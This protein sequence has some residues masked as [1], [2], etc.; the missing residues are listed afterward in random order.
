[1]ILSL[2]QII[3]KCV[4]RIKCYL[5]QHSDCH[6]LNRS[7]LIFTAAPE[8]ARTDADPDAKRLATGNPVRHQSAP[9]GEVRTIVELR[10]D[11]R[12][13]RE[14][15]GDDRVEGS[16]ERGHWQI[17]D[18]R[19]QVLVGVPLRGRGPRGQSRSLPVRR[20][21]PQPRP[22]GE[23]SPRPSSLSLDYGVDSKEWFVGLGGRRGRGVGGRG[24]RR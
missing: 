9:T 14:R 1:M 24:R 16:D 10:V 7:I 3:V 12:E 15:H 4:R 17:Q 2:C 18:L 8:S 6:M 21:D 23:R 5:G 20:T 13:E 22:H 11:Y 19:L